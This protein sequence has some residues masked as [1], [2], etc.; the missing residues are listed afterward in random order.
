MDQDARPLAVTIPGAAR[1]SGIGRTTL[2]GLIGEGE[3]QAR[4]C[5]RRTLILTGSLYDYLDKLPPATIRAPR[6]KAA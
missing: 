3:I 6:Q 1:M 5:G 2:Y 4:K